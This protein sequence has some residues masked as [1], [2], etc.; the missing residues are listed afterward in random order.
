MLLTGIFITISSTDRC[1]LVIC[2][3]YWSTAK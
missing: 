1:T 2:L 3:W